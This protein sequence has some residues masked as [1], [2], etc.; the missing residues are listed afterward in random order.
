MAV[1]EVTR[2][3]ALMSDDPKIIP[4]YGTKDKVSERKEFIAE[5]QRLHEEIRQ[6]KRIAHNARVMLEAV[7]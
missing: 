7:R 6:L 1:G 2:L 4:L 3:G 5:I